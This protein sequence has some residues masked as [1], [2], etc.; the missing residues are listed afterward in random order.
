MVKSMAGLVS[1]WVSRS[2]ELWKRVPL[3]LT[4]PCASAHQRQ[5]P[6]KGVFEGTRSGHVGRWRGV[7]DL[8]GRVEARPNVSRGR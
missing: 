6:H 7:G 4:Q 2:Q 3:G 8:G 5:N 1:A